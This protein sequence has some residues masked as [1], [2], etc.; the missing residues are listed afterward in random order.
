MKQQE[1]QAT[2]IV[3]AGRRATGRWQW[4]AAQ[5]C[6]VQYCTGTQRTSVWE[7]KQRG[8]VNRGD[9]QMILT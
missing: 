8:R 7:E 3:E 1:F 9:K 5:Y 2:K 6:T 4:R